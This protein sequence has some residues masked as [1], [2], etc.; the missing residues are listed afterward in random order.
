MLQPMHA[1][2][3]LLGSSKPSFERGTICSMENGSVEKSEGHLQYSQ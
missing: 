3:R 1:Y 2:A